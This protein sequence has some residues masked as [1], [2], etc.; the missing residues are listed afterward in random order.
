MTI[1]EDS[2]QVENVSD[3][4]HYWVIKPAAGPMSWGEC[5]GCGENKEF[6]NSVDWNEWTDRQDRARAYQ[7]NQEVIAARKA[8]ALPVGENDVD[9]ANETPS[10]W[11]D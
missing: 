4:A 7:G 2:I 11:E 5:R 10:Y 3:H 8:K 6:K 9:N 1:P